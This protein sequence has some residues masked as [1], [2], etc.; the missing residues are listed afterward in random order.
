MKWN[1]NEIVRS[2][3]SQARIK[4][5]YVDTGLVVLYDIKGIFE[6]GSTIVGDDSGNVLT[7]SEFEISNAYDIGYEPTYWE[8]L[9]DNGK[10]IIDGVVCDEGEEGNWIALDEHFTGKSSEDYQ[11]DY[12]VVVD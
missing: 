12:L 2:G 6:V 1:Y 4:N 5:Y 9:L 8:D 7:L 11:I 3:N 10:S